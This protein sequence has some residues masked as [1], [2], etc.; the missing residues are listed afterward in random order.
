MSYINRVKKTICHVM[1]GISNSSG[2]H[3]LTCD[4]KDTL[5][6]EETDTVCIRISPGFD[7]FNKWW[8]SSMAAV[9]RLKHAYLISYQNS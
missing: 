5:R 7:S 1:Q 2:L 8:C 4:N 3:E 9:I 6:Q